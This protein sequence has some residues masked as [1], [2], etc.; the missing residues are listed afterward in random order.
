MYFDGAYIIITKP[1]GQEKGISDSRKHGFFLQSTTVY[2][3]MLFF[4]RHVHAMLKKMFDISHMAWIPNVLCYKPLMAFILKEV[5]L[6]VRE[7]VGR[8]V[9]FPYC[10]CHCPLPQIMHIEF[11]PLYFYFGDKMAN[12]FPKELFILLQHFRLPFR[13]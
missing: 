12:F 11:S 7:K 1:L 5:W 2:L 10:S 13:F 3:D 6:E 8:E 9:T 4:A